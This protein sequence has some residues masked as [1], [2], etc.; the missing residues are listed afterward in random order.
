M[1]Q[2]VELVWHRFKIS[3]EAGKNIKISLYN[4]NSL[5]KRHHVT[6]NTFIVGVY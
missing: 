4:R 3:L 2:S 6:S 5:F 1:R